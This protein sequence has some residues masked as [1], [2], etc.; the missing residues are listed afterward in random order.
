MSGA[1]L[2][3]AITQRGQE[4]Q[5]WSAASLGPLTNGSSDRG[6]QLRLVRE[7]VDDWDKSVLFYVGASARRSA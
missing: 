3:Q 5:F 4:G 1:V 7:T 6:L 2:L